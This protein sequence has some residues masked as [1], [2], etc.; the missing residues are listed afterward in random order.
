MMNEG[1]LPISTAEWREM[2]CQFARIAKSQG[3]KADGDSKCPTCRALQTY[4][5]LWGLYC[6]NE[7][8][9]SN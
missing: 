3:C 4:D 9:A 8:S 2:A 1:F 5:I 7:L 6:R